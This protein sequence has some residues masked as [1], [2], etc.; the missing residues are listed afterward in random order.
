M[1]KKSILEII[2]SFIFFSSFLIAFINSSQNSNHVFL[3]LVFAF[4]GSGSGYY[5]GAFR[6]ASR[7]IEP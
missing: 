4:I 3:S 2:C 6:L 7:I 5:L 1:I